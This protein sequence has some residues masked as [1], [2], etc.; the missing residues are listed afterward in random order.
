MLGLP[1]KRR[2]LLS[3][4]GLALAFLLGGYLLPQQSEVRASI[5]INATPEQLLSE[6]RRLPSGAPWCTWT[7]SQAAG[8][9]RETA[10]LPERGIWFDV[11]D[12]VPRKAAILY[13]VQGDQLQLEWSDVRH[14]GPNP[15][16][17]LGAWLSSSS[18]QIE[19]T[20][21][22]A[23]LRKQFVHA[24]TPEQVPP[25][26]IDEAEVLVILVDDL[27][28][29][30]LAQAPTPHI[31]A[32]AASG[33]TF[34][35]LWVTPKCGPTRATMLTGRFHFRIGNGEIAK[36]HKNR[37]MGLEEL[38]LPEVIGTHRTAAYGKWHLGTSPTHPNET[39]FGHYA[40]SL[41][42][43]NGKSYTAWPKV[44]DGVESQETRYATSDVTDE[45]LAHDSSFKWVAY[46]AVHT[47]FHDPPA[48]LHPDTVLDGTQGT[49]VIAMTEA[50]DHEIGRL[51]AEHPQA[52]VFFL[53]D[54]GTTSLIGGGKGS[55]LES[56]INTPMIVRGPGVAEGSESQALINGADLFA[57]IAELYGKPT[58]S[59]D[60]ISFLPVLRGQ[61]G[62]R[63]WNYSCLFYEQKTGRRMHAIRDAEYKLIIDFQKEES[64]FSMPG[65]VPI[66]IST[67]HPE[68]LARLEALRALIP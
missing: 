34:R 38:T 5:A 18:R 41:G 66:E 49:Q 43:L 36:R 29:E 39:G 13:K 22:L 46:H 52:W 15:L 32:L 11:A 19:L 57:T 23:A 21:S 14:P 28:W 60:S 35:N 17:R 64:F 48:H 6:L 56:G 26:E 68:L 33:M 20:Q 50:V 37:S 10:F 53:C 25:S 7:P 42:N 24:P 55:M 27:G 8:G 30:T 59:E 65:E 51:L 31:D 45:A 62:A 3:L 1:M 9:L 54:N 2:L 47:P 63:T 58:Q 61:P 67:A 12:A 44:V 4:L 40:G 16:A